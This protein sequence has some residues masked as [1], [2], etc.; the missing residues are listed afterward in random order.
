MCLYCI[1][2]LIYVLHRISAWHYLEWNNDELVNDLLQMMWKAA[3]VAE[4]GVTVQSFDCG[5]WQMHR[6]LRQARQS[7][8]RDFKSCEA[9]I[10]SELFVLHWCSVPSRGV[11]CPKFR[12]RV[13]AS[14][15]TAISFSLWACGQHAVS[16]RGAT[17]TQRLNECPRTRIS[18]LHRF[19]SLKTV[20]SAAYVTANLECLILKLPACFH[21][22]NL[23]IFKPH[24]ALLRSK[25][26]VTASFVTT[27]YVGVC[28]CVRAA[29]ADSCPVP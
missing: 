29:V 9:R 28:P 20:K 8:D 12:G 7:L 3:V 4:F 18:E 23:L 17:S 6:K 11:C 24:L 27:N 15:S 10:L 22:Q 19:E 16:T 13:V 1:T 5:E 14:Y 2:V 21:S 26:F 25:V